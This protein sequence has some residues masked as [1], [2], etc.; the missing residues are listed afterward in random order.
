MEKKTP[1]QVLKS[2]YGYDSFRPKQKEIIQ[3]VLERRD[4]LVLM[5]TGGGKSQYQTENSPTVATPS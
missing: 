2:Y 4:S 5:P 1:E 3:N